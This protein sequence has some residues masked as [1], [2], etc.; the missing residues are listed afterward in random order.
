LCVLFDYFVQRKLCARNIARET[1]ERHMLMPKQQ[2]PGREASRMVL[3]EL[4]LAAYR[5]ATWLV[6]RSDPRAMIVL[7]AAYTGQRMTEIQ[8]VARKWLKLGVKGKHML[9][10]PNT[11]GVRTQKSDAF[12]YPRK[13]WV[14]DELAVYLAEHM[15]AVPSTDGNLVPP[16]HRLIEDI[17]GRQSEERLKKM[18]RRIYRQLT[19]LVPSEWFSVN[20]LRHTIGTNFFKQQ[21]PEG[22]TMGDWLQ[23]VADHIEH[24]PSMLVKKYVHIRKTI[25]IFGR[26]E[27][28]E[29]LEPMQRCE[30]PEELLTKL[31][32]YE[33]AGAPPKAIAVLR[34]WAAA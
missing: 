18:H 22:V 33:Q 3:P 13:V 24:S 14:D 1:V 34:R 10:P 5:L 26:G 2:N 11:E 27:E 15:K 20:S 16:K 32:Q 9:I 19:N 30:N 4:L 7:V 17:R 8:R 31:A 29:D 28:V 6:M 25:D 21:L 23:A 12:T